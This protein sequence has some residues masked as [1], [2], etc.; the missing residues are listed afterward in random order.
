MLKL[1]GWQWSLL[2]VSA[3]HLHRNICAGLPVIAALGTS[4]STFRALECTATSDNKRGACDKRS[5]A[6]C[7]YPTGRSYLMQTVARHLLPILGS[8]ASVERHAVHDAGGLVR[9]MPFSDLSLRRLGVDVDIVGGRRHNQQSAVVIDAR[10][11]ASPYL[12]MKQTEY[13]S[14]VFM[15]L[16]CTCD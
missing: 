2:Q 3:G 1:F 9:H 4:P 12:P 6:V 10:T 13:L 8:V 11:S 5:N 15:H 14:Q 7:G 16:L